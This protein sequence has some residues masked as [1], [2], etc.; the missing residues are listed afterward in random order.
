[1][2]VQG[3]PCCLYRAIDR[4][5]NLVD[6]ILSETC[7]VAAEV[8]GH[9]PEQM[10]TDGHTA[11]PGAIQE[12]LGPEVEHR[13]NQHLNNRRDGSIAASTQPILPSPTRP[14]NEQRCAAIAGRPLAVARQTGATAKGRGGARSA[15]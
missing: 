8:V 2:R 3:R 11:Y 5:G 10:T 7:D 1:V 14:R 4:D 13:S 9:C 12:T 15:V 6:S